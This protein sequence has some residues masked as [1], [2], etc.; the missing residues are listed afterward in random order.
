MT[1]HLAVRSPIKSWQRR[2][3][4]GSR[5]TRHLIVQIQLALEMKVLIGHG[6]LDVWQLMGSPS[7][8]RVI[9]YLAVMKVQICHEKLDVWQKIKSKKVKDDWMLRKVGS[10][11][12]V[13]LMQ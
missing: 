2:S 5:L 1:E 9:G 11:R 4:S 8:S 3:S 13:D 10:P 6:R 7:T 12:E